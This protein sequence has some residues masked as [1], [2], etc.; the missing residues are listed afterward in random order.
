M[1][2]LIPCGRTSLRVEKIWL[3]FNPINSN[4]GFR[5]SDLTR[6]CVFKI[7]P[8]TS[9]SLYH[10][11]SILCSRNEPPSPAHYFCDPASAM[12][13][14]ALNEKLNTTLV[15]STEELTCLFIS[16]DNMAG[17][18]PSPGA[19]N[20]VILFFQKLN[21]AWIFIDFWAVLSSSAVLFPRVCK[22]KFSILPERV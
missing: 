9:L 19:R 17:K 5:S 3:A 6:S 18:R 8:W 4:P 20:Q 12:V 11:I 7:H 1:I 13:E 2:I 21:F 14:Q 10:A 15:N 16:H 22:I